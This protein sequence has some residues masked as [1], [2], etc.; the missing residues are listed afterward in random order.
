MKLRETDDRRIGLFLGNGEIVM[1]CQEVVRLC[2][3]LLQL[4][5]DISD[6]ADP[7]THPPLQPFE[8]ETV[9][10]MHPAGADVELSELL[11]EGRAIG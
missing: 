7:P 5:V 1:T 3:D 4:A 8:V 9:T 11:G 2:I 6:R 10:I